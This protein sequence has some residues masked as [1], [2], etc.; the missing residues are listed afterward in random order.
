MCCE[1]VATKIEEVSDCSRAVLS[2]RSECNW[3]RIVSNDKFCYRS[4]EHWRSASKQLEP[5]SSFSVVDVNAIWNS[6]YMESS[7]QYSDKVYLAIHTRTVL[8]T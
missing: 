1:K 4:L 6:N 2:V 7:P 8:C 5:K 3:F